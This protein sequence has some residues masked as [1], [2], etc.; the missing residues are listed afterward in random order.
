MT[1]S[2]SGELGVERGALV[3][4]TVH[5]QWIQVGGVC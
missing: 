1:I 2:C 5:S 3:G 4:V